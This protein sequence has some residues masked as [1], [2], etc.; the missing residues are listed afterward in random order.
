MGPSPALEESVVARRGARSHVA[1]PGLWWLSEPPLGLPVSLYI[2]CIAKGPGREDVSGTE[3]QALLRAGS[4]RSRGCLFLVGPS[5][6]VNI[7]QF[8]RLKGNAFF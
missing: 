2:L 5:G 7:L 3:V 4:A 1:P 6:G 8:F